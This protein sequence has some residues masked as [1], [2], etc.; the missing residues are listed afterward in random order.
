[1]FKVRKRIAVKK[2]KSEQSMCM[3]VGPNNSEVELK[4]KSVIKLGKSRL[5]VFRFRVD[6]KRI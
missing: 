4:E 1:M 5:D 6:K 3:V 2:A